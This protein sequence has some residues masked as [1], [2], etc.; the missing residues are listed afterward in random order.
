VVLNKIIIINYDN[1]VF[2]VYA[3]SEFPD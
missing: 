2:L 1:L 3:N